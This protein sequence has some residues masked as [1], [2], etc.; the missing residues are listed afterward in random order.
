MK[1]EIK[2]ERLEDLGIRLERADVDAIWMVISANIA[3]AFCA[4]VTLNTSP[5]GAMECV[6]I[7]FLRGVTCSLLLLSVS[8]WWMLYE[9]NDLWFRKRVRPMD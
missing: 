3:L 4:W 2:K 7:W 5:M 8:L 9:E 1:Q 6:T